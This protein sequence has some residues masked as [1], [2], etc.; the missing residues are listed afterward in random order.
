MRLNTP[1]T[2][3]EYHISD[4]DSIVSTTDLQGNITYAN[5]YFIEVSGF[6]EEELIGAPQNIVRHPDMPVEAYADLW[7]TIKSGL[8]WTGVVKNRCKNGDH[9]WVY[10]NVTPVVENG[11]A[12][13]YMSVR[14]KPSVV[15]VR[16]AELLYK[17][18]KNGNPN[19]LKLRQGSVVRT[20]L[21]TKLKSL[22]NF[23]ISQRIAM[24]VVLLFLAIASILTN[25]LFSQGKPFISNIGMVIVLSL[26][27]FNTLYLWYSFHIAVVVPSQQALTASKI[28]AGGDLTAK[29]ETNR[30]DEL[31]QVLRMLRQVKVNLHSI[32]GDVRKNSE[33]IRVA[34]Q[35][36]AAGNMELSGRTESQASSLEETAAS[37]EEFA[38]TV[39][40]NTDN[41]NIASNMANDA[42][43]IAD[44][45]GTITKQ[46]V[47]TM[48]EINLS[49]KRMIDITGII[50]GIAFQTN[51][52]ALNAAVEAARAGE[53]G[54][55][56]A[57]VASEVR[58]LAQ[59][60]AAAAKEIKQL[61]DATVEKIRSGTSLTAQ[62]GN[63]M[64]EILG[65]TNKVSGIMNEIASASRE[66]S[67][68]I[69][70]VNEAV[71]LMDTVTQ[72][73][74]ALVEE[75]AAAAGSLSEQT[76]TL[77]KALSVFKLEHNASH[78]VQKANGAT[79]HSRSST[80]QRLLT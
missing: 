44:H 46:M 18:L 70:Q 76:H 27:F 37:M 34:T 1:V 42:L 53:Q 56:F 50:E 45:G 65:S 25:L 79:L 6:T 15:Q 54:R 61:I 28:M 20:D 62:A 43:R 38:S 8:P 80:S 69:I 9:Y 77:V 58:S 64:Q 33:H 4:S 75:A 11:K 59:R 5:P 51:I 71:T 16:Q 57:V 24:N 49:S 12:T 40:Q 7:Y 13:G 19:K 31:G 21:L 36:I 30:T 22:V 52:L 29:I 60:S 17:E 10:A 67:A 74:A 35:E 32:V 55:G 78:S 63:A 48:E 3:N 23:S 39:S 68:G 66:Q 41:A 26:A 14:T 72:Q 47:E 2:Q 73:N